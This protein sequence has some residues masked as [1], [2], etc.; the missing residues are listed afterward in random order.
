MTVDEHKLNF[1]KHMILSTFRKRKEDLGLTFE[2]LAEMMGVT[3]KYASI[4]LS[5]KRIN[6]NDNIY[7]DSFL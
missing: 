4:K 6:S 2:E 1:N 3:E 5:R 7:L